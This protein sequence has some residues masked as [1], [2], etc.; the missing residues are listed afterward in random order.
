MFGKYFLLSLQGT[1]LCRAKI[2]FN[3]VLFSNSFF[4][5]IC[6]RYHIL[7]LSPNKITLE[8]FPMIFSRC[9]IILHFTFR[10]M[11]QFALHFVKDV[12]YLYIYSI[13][14]GCPVVSAPFGES[15]LFQDVLNFLKSISIILLS[16]NI[17]DFFVDMKPRNYLGRNA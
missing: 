16:M 11:I 1:M 3:E 12:M 9:S 13:R 7:R 6:L 15:K 14:Y 5:E 10:H 2:L 8:I 4:Y 17:T